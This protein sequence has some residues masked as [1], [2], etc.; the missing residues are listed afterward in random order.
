MTI[1]SPPLERMSS[2]RFHASPTELILVLFLFCV[3][4]SFLERGVSRDMDNLY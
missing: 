4:E 1:N 2:V 3:H